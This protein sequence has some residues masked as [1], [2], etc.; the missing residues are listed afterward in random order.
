M[1]LIAIPIL[2]P[3]V[4]GSNLVKVCFV[5]LMTFRKPLVLVNVPV[6]SAHCSNRWCIT[7][8]NTVPNKLATAILSL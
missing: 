4:T 8:Q 1:L 5:I 7:I 6:A 2:K 3:L